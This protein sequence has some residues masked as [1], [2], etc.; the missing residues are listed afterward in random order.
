[1]G[2]L[3]GTAPESLLDL[4][5]APVTLNLTGSGTTVYYGTLS[6]SGAININGPAYRAWPRPAPTR[7]IPATSS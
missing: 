2:Y 4:A 5:S 1:M 6:G 3:G 7:A